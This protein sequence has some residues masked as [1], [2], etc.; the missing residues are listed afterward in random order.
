M[1]FIYNTIYISLISYAKHVPKNCLVVADIEQLSD[2]RMFELPSGCAN[3]LEKGDSLCFG[4]R[5]LRVKRTW[6]EAVQL[7]SRHGAS[8]GTLF[9]FGTCE[10][11]S[12]TRRIKIPGLNKESAL[13]VDKS[14]KRLLI[15]GV[16][17]IGTQNLANMRENLQSDT[18]ILTW[19]ESFIDSP[20]DIHSSLSDGRMFLL[21][22]GN[23]RVLLLPSPASPSRSITEVIA[24]GTIGS[25]LSQLRLPSSVAIVHSENSPRPYSAVFIADTGNDRVVRWRK[26]AKRA[27]LVLSRLS[28]GIFSPTQVVLSQESLFVVDRGNHAGSLGRILKVSSV[29][30]LNADYNISEIPS[31]L[32]TVD[33]GN[34]NILLDVSVSIIAEF[35]DCNDL[36]IDVCGSTIIASSKRVDST[37]SIQGGHRTQILNEGFSS[38]RCYSDDTY[39]IGFFGI[40]KGN[41]VM[42]QFFDWNH[43]QKGLSKSVYSSIEL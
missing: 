21:D 16:N 3:V 22:S 1:R 28:H 36:S 4:E 11:Q 17:W 9:E 18:S 19:Y 31:V 2:A 25:S 23:N 32:W 41:E 26:G 29:A 38:V 43:R 10:G 34:G 20:K 27:E 35:A 7:D 37:W 42:F 33:D 13:A 30:L 15:L 8:K 5:E 39:G 24:G 6:G 40:G 14:N 12:F